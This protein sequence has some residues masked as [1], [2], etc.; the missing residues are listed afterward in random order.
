MPPD[1]TPHCRDRNA[2]ITLH[3]AVYGIIIG[4]AVVFLAGAWSFFGSG[5]YT[6]LVLV[7]VTLFFIFAVGIPGE[8]GRIWTNHHGEAGRPQAP[9]VPFRRW[10]RGEFTFRRERLKG[11]DGAAEALLPIA[12]VAISMVLFAICR[13][14]A[15]G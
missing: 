6:G 11:S 7:V 12:A 14:I 15:V 10:L 13:F 3:P 9:P 8:L 5:H 4:L 1:D 2:L